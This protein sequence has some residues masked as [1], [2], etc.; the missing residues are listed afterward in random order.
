[1]TVISVMVGILY[2]TEWNRLTHHVPVWAIGGD[3]WGILRGAQYVGW[4]YFGGVYDQ[5]T[6][7]NSLPGMPLLLAPAAI[8]ID[9]LQLSAS[10]G[11]ITLVHPTAAFVLEP[12]E[13]L[14][15]SSVL[16]PVDA[17]AQR[18]GV[19]RRR[20]ILLCIC[21]AVLAWPV[22]A[23]WGHAEDLVALTFALCAL[24][25]SL[26][27][28]W[29]AA[30]W[31]LGVGICF[32]PYVCVIAPVLIGMSPRAAWRST[33]PRLAALP[34]TLLVL[35][36]SEN[37]GGTFRAVVSQPTPPAVNHATPWIALAPHLSVPSLRV[38]H[39]VELWNHVVV[40]APVSHGPSVLVA[41][42]PSRA[43]GLVVA[44]AAGLV[45]SRRHLSTPQIVWIVGLVLASRALFESV[46]TPYY[47]AAPMI[48][49]AILASRQSAG[50]FGMSCLLM[51]T[52]TVYT[53]F[54]LSPWIWWSPIVAAIGLLL[55]L[56]QQFSARQASDL[57]AVGLSSPLT[58][59]QLPE[60]R[61][62]K[63]GLSRPLIKSPLA[64]QRA[65]APLPPA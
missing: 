54:H 49:L 19:P 41:G 65:S 3:L 4:G 34:A 13:L 33:L 14:L 21:V 9:H 27:R 46:M 29:H 7:I 26:D 40:A 37:P 23:V 45:V 25:R 63:T 44:I 1:M 53:Y 30:A 6:G 52:T 42:G 18:L 35:A 20:R 64:G 36:F 47:L 31:L 32:Q 5:S 38:P 58:E 17:L 62:A 24:L 39:A 16:F 61:I 28:E 12:I 10:M 60:R 22:G 43:L 50:R 55:W 2:M 56:T 59:D 11:N 8:L 48:V 57:A 15:G 51:L